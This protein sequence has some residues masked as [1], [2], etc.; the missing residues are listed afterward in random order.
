MRRYRWFWLLA[1]LGL[2]GCPKKP[3][4]PEAQPDYGGIRQR[5][6]SSHQSLDQ[7]SQKQQER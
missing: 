4:T 2:A 7:E 1:L 6:E 3:A 5:S